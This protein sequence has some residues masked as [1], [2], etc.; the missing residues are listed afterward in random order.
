MFQ[1]NRD[2]T[3]AACYTPDKAS[4]EDLQGLSSSLSRG[5]ANVS[6]SDPIMF[7]NISQSDSYELK[8]VRTNILQQECGNAAEWIN[9][10]N[11]ELVKDIGLISAR[12]EF[13]S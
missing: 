6:A 5:S 4:S 10:L 2:Q 9:E 8:S 11:K 3:N 1:S 13:R 12:M 7:L